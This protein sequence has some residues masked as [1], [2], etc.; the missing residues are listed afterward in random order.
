M[1]AAVIIVSEIGDKV[2]VVSLSC[3]Y[4]ELR[5]IGWNVQTFLIGAL[6]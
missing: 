5:L 1:L 2:R 6:A 3:L 4:V